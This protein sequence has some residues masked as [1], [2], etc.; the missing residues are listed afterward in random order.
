M[1]SNPIEGVT[2]KDFT[3]VIWHGMKL[4]LC[5]AAYLLFIPVI[6]FVL[7][8]FFRFNVRRFL[9]IYNTIVAVAVTVVFA[10]DCVLYSYWG[11]RTD[12][13]LF[14]YL[15]D[16]QESMNSIT[17]KDV[18]EFLIIGAV[19]LLLYFFLY[20]ITVTKV[21]KR[22]FFSFSGESV[23]RKVS[24]IAMYIILI[25]VIYLFGRGGVSTA[26]ANTGMV[27]Y[28]DNQKLNI[29]AIN[30]SFNLVYSLLKNDDFAKLLYDGNGKETQEEKQ[31]RNFLTK[32]RPNI[33]III[34]ESF[35]ADVTEIFN[36]KYPQMQGKEIT[37]CL[38][39]AGDYS[40]VFKNAYSNGM[41]TDRGI[42]SVLSGFLAQPDM[43]VIK[44]PEKTRSLPSIAKT[45]AKNGYNTSMLY[46]GDV[47]FANM[48]SYFYSSMYKSITDYKSFGIK[49]RLSKWGVND[50][51]TF[52]Y[53]YD[54]LLKRDKSRP[55]FA[56]FLTLSSHEPFDVD[57]HKFDNPYLNSVAYTDSCLGVFLDK[58]KASDLWNNTLVV[59]VADHGYP[60]PQG[61]AQENPDKYHIPLLFT[62]GVIKEPAV[63]ERFVNQTDI[64][65]TLFSAMGIEC[66][67]FVYSRDV[68]N[69]YTQNYA[70]FVYTDGFGFMDSTGVT[71][72]DNTSGKTLLGEDKTREMKGK[73][74]LQ[75]LYKDI[76]NR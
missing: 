52:S 49:D 63:V 43:T 23:K 12:A 28:C 41:R 29:A 51:I 47:D 17:F 57:M 73:V 54:D 7:D 20:K 34:L 65:K 68:F 64:A 31:Q 1:L 40:I 76:A 2:F 74:L 30:P 67:D 24:V 15:M 18:A 59:L 9:Y 42:V 70:F 39:S 27:Y 3:D 69:P 50:G 25:P 53:L 4:D 38:N 19:Y 35:M 48:R 75:M 58:L 61:L 21:Y 8:V 44:Y 66:S 46:G 55:F 45:L 33:L 22:F 32:D 10:F 72:W 13:T 14:F 36:G 62:G 5:F 11:F 26:S 56:T 6:I 37:P 60:Y 71:V 16:W